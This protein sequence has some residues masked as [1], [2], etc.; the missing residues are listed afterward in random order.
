MYNYFPK[1]Q[2]GALIGKIG[3]QWFHIGRGVTVT[4]FASAVLELD[5]NDTDPGN[6]S[7]RFRVEIAVRHR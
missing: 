5:V 4:P 6:N 2:H 3:S 7:A 1:M